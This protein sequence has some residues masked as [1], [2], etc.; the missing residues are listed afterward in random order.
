MTVW[1]SRPRKR[2]QSPHHPVNHVSAEIASDSISQQSLPRRFSRLR[3]RILDIPYSVTGR[4]FCKGAPVCP[5]FQNPDDGFFFPHFPP[6][7]FSTE[8]APDRRSR[9]IGFVHS[10]GDPHFGFPFVEPI[11]TQIEILSRSPIFDEPQSRQI[12]HWC[13]NFCPSLILVRC[14]FV[15]ALICSF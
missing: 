6:G 4:V 13:E 3:C 5:K 10:G 7:L 2:V 11:P 8:I 12:D 9:K 15:P 14:R 1:V